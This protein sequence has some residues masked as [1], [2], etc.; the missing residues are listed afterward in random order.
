MDE[1]DDVIF[2]AST[3]E[4]EALSGAQKIKDLRE[5]IKE[6]EKEKTEYLDG[7]QRARA[8]YANLQKTT[9]EDRKRL[10][11]IIEQS[12]VE[13]LLPVLDSFSLAMANKQVWESVDQN[14]R[15]GVEYIQSQLFTILKDRGVQPFG[16]VSDLFDPSKH[17]AVGEV[18]TTDVSQDHH[19]AQVLQQ[20]YILGEVVIR[21]AR[22]TVYTLTEAA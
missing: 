9:D 15:K 22:V 20:G 7:W 8:D 19:I 5:K 13:D 4:G 17:E 12:F 16:I 1:H 10:R 11:T 18:S 14:W 21:P 6:L 2:E 3:E